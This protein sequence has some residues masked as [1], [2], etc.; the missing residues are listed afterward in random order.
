MW[1]MTQPNRVPSDFEV[2]EKV[3]GASYTTTYYRRGHL[4]LI[5]PD[6]G[7]SDSEVEARKNVAY[8]MKLA[9][10]MGRIGMIVALGSLKTMDPGARRVYSR[11]LDHSLVVAVA[12]VVNSALARAMG[13]FFLGLAKPKCPT[14]LVD[15]IESGAAWLE[16]ILSIPPHAARPQ[17]EPGAST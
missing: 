15:S 5:V 16:T 14:R 9:K 13:S 11:E 8:Q 17:S 7:T 12:L 6:P 10:E 3:H 4:L 2:I 1:R